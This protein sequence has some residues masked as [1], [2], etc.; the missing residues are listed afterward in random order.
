LSALALAQEHGG[1]A[2]ALRITG[3]DLDDAER[4]DAL[5]DDLERVLAGPAENASLR[6][7]LA[8]GFLAGRVAHRARPRRSYDPSSFLMDHDLLVRGAE[9]QSILRLP[10]F[11]EDLFVGRQL[12]DIPEM[13]A[14]VRR[15]CIENYTAALTGERQRFAFNS[16]GHAYNVQAVPVRGADGAIKAVLAVAV[17]ALPAVGRL[18]AA[19]R[20]ERAAEALED[21]A[22]LAEH[23]AD[24]YRLSGQSEAEAQE[25]EAAEKARRAARQARTNAW[26]HRSEGTHPLP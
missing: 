18:R 10:W 6:E 26:R 21:S 4:V 3:L 8:L 1:A 20:Y 16:Y 9:G 12:P 22:R 14:R 2:E 23:H 24:L 25:R 15:L 11:D 5:S 7:V 19:D 13:P 17:P